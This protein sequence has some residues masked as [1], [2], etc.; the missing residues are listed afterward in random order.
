MELFCYYSCMTER[1]H[2]ASKVG[3][4][5]LSKSIGTIR[6]AIN[7]IRN[8]LI[9]DDYT[10]GIAL[11]AITDQIDLLLDYIS[12]KVSDFTR[13]KAII[14]NDIASAFDTILMNL[15]YGRLNEQQTVE[16]QH[17]LLKMR[18][19]ATGKKAI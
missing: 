2:E 19:T 6:D 15:T 1:Y 12:G 8:N 17:N 7:R 4:E 9:D 3:S 13:T 18:E 14:P 16:L 10:K 5:Q 11:N